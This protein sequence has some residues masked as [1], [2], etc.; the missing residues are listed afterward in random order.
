M[1]DPSIEDMR[2]FLIEHAS[3]S[4]EFDRE[5]AMYWFASLYHGGQSSNLYSALC[6][7][8]YSP[9]PLAKEPELGESDSFDLLVLKYAPETVNKSIYDIDY[10]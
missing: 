7:S 5:E 2:E 4:D 9:G 8:E 6:Q 10:Q 3:Y 1:L